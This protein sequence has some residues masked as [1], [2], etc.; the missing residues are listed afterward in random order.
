MQADEEARNNF[1]IY[2]KELSK[3]W[4]I[5]QDAEGCKIKVILGHKG[6]GLEKTIQSVVSQTYKFIV[7]KHGFYNEK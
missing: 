2:F 5:N 7:L 1:I 4:T 6:I 3:I